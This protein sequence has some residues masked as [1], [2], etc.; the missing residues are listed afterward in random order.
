MDTR[1][2]GPLHSDPIAIELRNT[3]FPTAAGPVDGL[4]DDDAAAGFVAALGPRLWNGPIALVPYPTAAELRQARDVIR[5]LLDGATSRRGLFDPELIA[6]LNRLAAAARPSPMAELAVDNQTLR[7]GIDYHGASGSEI[8]LAAFAVDAIELVT[9]PRR[10]LLRHCD[11][12]NCGL[13][14]LAADARRK[15]CSDACGNRAR[16]ARHHRRRHRVA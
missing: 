2:R 6:E 16:Q 12:P 14:Y 5:P 9:G 8:A 1:Y 4:V 7:A 3:L 10:S 15:W 11:G 13:L